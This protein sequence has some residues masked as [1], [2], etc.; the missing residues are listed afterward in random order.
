[1]FIAIKV[2][3]GFNNNYNN[4]LFF[5]SSATICIAYLIFK[6]KWNFETALSHVNNFI[7]Q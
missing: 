4:N 7:Y 2:F 1:M 5:Y 6:K 3:L